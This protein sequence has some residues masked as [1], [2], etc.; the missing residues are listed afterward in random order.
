[1]SRW[2]KERMYTTSA[3]CSFLPVYVQQGHKTTETTRTLQRGKV[4][5][6]RTLRLSIIKIKNIH[7]AANLINT[8][9]YPPLAKRK[10]I[11]VYY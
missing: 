2:K 9:S 3:R 7:I 4:A 6:I 8:Y 11:V 10:N 5:H 1:M